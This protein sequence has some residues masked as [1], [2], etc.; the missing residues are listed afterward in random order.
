M[1]RR[2]LDAARK[3]WIAEADTEVERRERE[4]SDFLTYRNAE[5]LFADFHAHR[6]TFISNLS[7]ANVAPKLAQDLARHSDI[8]LTMNVYTHL[9]RNAQQAAIE[10]L[11][12]PPG[13]S[14]SRAG[15]NRSQVA[16]DANA[17]DS[18]V[19]GTSRGI[20]GSASGGARSGAQQITSNKAH[21]ASNCTE[22]PLADV[23]EPSAVATGSPCGSRVLCINTD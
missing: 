6:H 2:D 23:S 4:K 16:S 15:H 3:R 20:P 9:E 7:K 5:G 10:S 21:T 19:A 8:R 17:G 13:G 14:R 11:P 1:M 12:G 18:L 22:G